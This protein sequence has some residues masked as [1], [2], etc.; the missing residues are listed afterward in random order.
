MRRSENTLERW[1]MAGFALLGMMA[2][3]AMVAKVLTP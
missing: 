2:M 3:G 1:A